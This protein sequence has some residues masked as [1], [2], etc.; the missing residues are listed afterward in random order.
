MRL[1]CLHPTYSISVMI[2]KKIFDELVEWMAHAQPMAGNT[3]N[4]SIGLRGPVVLF[5]L[6]SIFFGDF[7]DGILVIDINS[8]APY[9]SAL[10]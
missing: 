5:E 3:C 1:L 2:A 6:N 10:S 9:A 4:D 8:P 7:C